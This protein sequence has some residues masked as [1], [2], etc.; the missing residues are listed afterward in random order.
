[1]TF[2]TKLRVN[3]NIIQFQISSRRENK[4]R[5][6]WVTKIRVPRK[7]LSNN[8]ALSDAEVNIFGPSNRGGI[9]DLPCLRTLLAILQKS[10]ESQLFGEWWTL[11]LLSYASQAGS[12]TFLEQLLV[13]LNFTLDS[14]VILMSYDGS[15]SSW[16]PWI[17]LAATEEPILKI[18]SY[19]TSL[20]WTPRLSQS[21]WK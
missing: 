13:C 10:P 1:M 7:N 3:R 16:K 8:F 12:R 5:D 4:P 20:K 14:E 18:L 15:S 11:F 6:Y 17:W 9:A 2:L 21:T 19:V